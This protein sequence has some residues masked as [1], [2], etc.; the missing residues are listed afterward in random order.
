MR[1]SIFL[2]VA[3][4]LF[5]LSSPVSSAEDKDGLIVYYFHTNARCA[6]CLKI[7]KYTEESLNTFFA[8][9]L[10][11]GEISFRVINVEEKENSHFVDDYQ[12]YTKSVVLSQVRDGSEVKYKNL[13]KVWQYLMDEEKFY[14]YIRSETQ[15]FLDE[16]GGKMKAEEAGEDSSAA[17]EGKKGK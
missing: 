8:D 11:S 16:T 6:S 4:V 13:E 10:E 2:A 12:L 5:A 15:S 7:E 14:E 9:Q 3:L 17:D 1:K